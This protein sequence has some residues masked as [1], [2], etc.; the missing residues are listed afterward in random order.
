MTALVILTQAVQLEATELSES[1]ASS[2][3]KDQPEADNVPFPFE[4]FHQNCIYI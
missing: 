4:T 2:A 1:Y 3:G